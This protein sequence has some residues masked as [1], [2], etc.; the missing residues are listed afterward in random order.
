MLWNDLGITYQHSKWVIRLHAFLSVGLQ[1]LVSPADLWQA[2]W[3]G[4]AGKFASRGDFTGPRCLFGFT[5]EPGRRWGRC[6]GGLEQ[7]LLLP[8]QHHVSQPAS[9]LNKH[10]ADGGMILFGSSL[11]LM[12]SLLCVCVCVCRTSG[13]TWTAFPT[14]RGWWRSNT[15]A[16]LVW[17]PCCLEC[18]SLSREQAK[19]GQFKMLFFFLFFFSFAY[20]LSMCC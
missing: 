14:S 9:R 8:L 19:M 6:S 5:R 10:E 11:C 18:T 7:V 20:I 13:V 2:E 4:P 16:M 17:S 15:W 12:L 1:L 3:R